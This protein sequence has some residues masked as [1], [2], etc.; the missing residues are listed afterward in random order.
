MISLITIIPSVLALCGFVHA[1][2]ATPGLTLDDVDDFTIVPV[3]WELPVKPDDP[4]DATVTVEGTIQ[5][6]IAKMD[7]G[8]PGWNQTFQAGLGDVSYVSASLAALAALKDP[9]YDC[10]IK[11]DMAN[12]LAIKWGIHYLRAIPGKAK[13]GPGPKN[14]G[15]VSCS[16]DSAIYWCNEDSSGDKELYWGQIADL[17]QGILDNCAGLTKVKGQGTYKDDKWSVVVRF[18]KGSEGNC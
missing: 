9:T 3:Y 6:A 17:A 2:P 10:K 11:T 18:P 14:C 4:N 1:A 7:T 15:R 5:Q 8:Y 16:W 12:I 13:N